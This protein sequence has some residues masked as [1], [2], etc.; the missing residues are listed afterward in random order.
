MT[1]DQAIL[2]AFAP[3][4][5]R[6]VRIQSTNFENEVNFA[7]DDVPPFIGGDWG[8]TFVVQLLLFSRPTI[9]PMG[10]LAT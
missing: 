8:T 4:N 10:W 3:T 9:C 6:M 5:D 2:L 1:I 7:L